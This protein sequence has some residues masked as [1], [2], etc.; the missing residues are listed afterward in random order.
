MVKDCCK[1]TNREKKCQRKSD[2]KIFKLPRKFS[3]KKCT[4]GKIRGFTMRSSCAP[5]KN[6]KKTYKKNKTKTKKHKTER[7]KIK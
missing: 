3:K 2:K 6:C 5:Y 7:K 4:T 1:I